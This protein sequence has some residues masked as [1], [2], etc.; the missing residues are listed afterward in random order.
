MAKRARKRNSSASEQVTSRSSSEREIKKSPSDTYVK[1]I[2]RTLLDSSLAGVVTGATLTALLAWAIT[3]WQLEREHAYWKMQRAVTVKYEGY[4][5]KLEIYGN[6]VSLFSTYRQLSFD[7]RKV[8]L[9]NTRSRALVLELDSAKTGL[10]DETTFQNYYQ[11]RNKQEEVV[12]DITVLLYQ[13]QRVYDEQTLR[14]AQAFINH[15]KARKEPGRY[16]LE[17]LQILRD[18]LKSGANLREVYWS[19]Y[20]K[21]SSGLADPAFVQ[22]T[23]LLLNAMRISLEADEIAFDVVLDPEPALR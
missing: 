4:K 10:L 7:I 13:M 23:E 21:R 12:N 15:M 22:E 2:F 6:A 1:K 16:D 17:L 8:K 18:S 5:T 9:E 14:Q 19:E 11:L 3:S 20:S